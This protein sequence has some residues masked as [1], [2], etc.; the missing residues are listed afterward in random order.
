L[1]VTFV[2]YEESLLFVAKNCQ[3]DSDV[4]SCTHLYF[5][6]VLFLVSVQLVY[7]LFFVDLLT[8]F[9]SV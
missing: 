8:V 5:T 2:I 1:C 9:V 7:L 4:R 6:A 3:T